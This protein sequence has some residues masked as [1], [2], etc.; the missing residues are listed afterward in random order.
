M[1]MESGQ[2]LRLVCFELL[3]EGSSFVCDS[4]SY[5]E[6]ASLAK[7]QNGDSLSAV[8]FIGIIFMTM[9]ITHE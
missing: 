8:S 9:K 5:K 3:V 7:G 2:I 4:G 6:S 1:A